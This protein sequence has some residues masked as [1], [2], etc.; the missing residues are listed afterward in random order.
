MPGDSSDIRHANGYLYSQVAMVKN[1]NLTIGMSYDA[2]DNERSEKD[3][4][5]PKAWP[6]L[7]SFFAY[8]V[9]GG[10]IPGVDQDP[11]CRPDN[12]AD[13]D[14]RLQSVL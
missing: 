3:Q 12:R 2:F 6:C 7:E 4:F 8:H 10:R 1:V 11:D 9:S 14:C 5:N 13:S